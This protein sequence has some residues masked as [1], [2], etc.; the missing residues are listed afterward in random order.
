M[1]AACVTRPLDSSRAG[2]PRRAAAG[3]PP[4]ARHAGPEPRRHLH[5][6]RP[7]AARGRPPAGGV[8]ERRPPQGLRAR[9]RRLGRRGGSGPGD[10]PRRLPRRR[11]LPPPLGRRAAPRAVG[12]DE[13]EALLAAD[14]AP[15][16]VVLVARPGRSEPAE[17]PGEPTRWSPHGVALEA[18]DPAAVPAV[19]QGRAGVQDEG[20]QLVALALAWAEVDGRDER[21]LDLCA[22]PGG[23]AALLAAL[24]AGQ[25]A[26]L[27]GAERLPHRAALVA[28]R[29]GRSRRRARRGHGG[30]HPPGL[31]RRG[32]RPGAGRRSLHRAGGAAPPARGPVAAYGA[33]PRRAGAAPDTAAGLGARCRPAGRRGR[34]RHLLP[35]PRG[36]RRGRAGHAR[37]TL[38]TSVWTTPARLLDEVPDADGPLPGTVQLWPH[39]HGTD[40]MFIALLRKG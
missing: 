17:L 20:S 28:A 19:A 16:R 15:P 39:R 36:D 26:R 40:A 30:R 5:Q 18:G 14:N 23:K 1:L 29:A 34:L 25:G 24:A 22:G 32:V 21:W 33:G 13:I 9:P 27:L 31:A 37:G 8:R 3:H 38:R 11:P 12:D 4:A 10:R 35:G 7:G 2:R 6:R